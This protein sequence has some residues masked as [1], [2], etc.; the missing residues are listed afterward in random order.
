MSTLQ[1]LYKSN[2]VLITGM[3]RSGTSL[4]AT[5]AEKLGLDTGWR[6]DRN[7]ECIERVKMSEQI[8][9]A[10]GADWDT[11]QQL[12]CVSA[13]SSLDRHIIE[14]LEWFSTRYWTWFCHPT[15][16]IGKK[17]IWGWKDPRL[18]ITLK[19]W[20]MVWPQV[21][22]IYI[23]RNE[24]DIKKSLLKRSSIEEYKR[25]FFPTRKRMSLHYICEFL[26]DD[27]IKVY[28]NNFYLN[29]SGLKVLSLRYEE[30]LRE[31]VE[32]VRKIAD[33]I[34]CQDDKLI[35]DASKIVRR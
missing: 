20:K 8:L 12:E 19:Y 9:S 33:F 6:K 1:S 35:I 17:S 29:S 16:S 31:P 22:L 10:F 26:V 30:L 11:P 23:E 34:G 3:H 32:Q 4:A 27:L 15:Y 2:P 25:T 24:D 28:K 18:C 21:R 14:Q 5:I 7:Y 13:D